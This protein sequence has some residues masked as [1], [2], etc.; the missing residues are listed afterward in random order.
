[1]INGI[2]RA[3]ISST[4]N[5]EGLFPLARF[6]PKELLPLG[7][8]TVIQKVVDEVIDCGVKD[9]IFISSNQ[10]KEVVNHFT[11]FSDVP[12]EQEK[13]KEKYS[14][15]DFCGVLQKKCSDAY[16]VYRAKEKIEEDAFIVIIPD[17]VFYGKK[18]SVEQI[19]SVYRTTQKPVVALKEALNYEE[20]LCTVEVEKI[21]NRF[22]K[23]KSINENPGKDDFPKLALAGRYIFTQSIFDY[24]GSNVSIAE[25]LNKMITAGKT[26]YGNHCEGDWFS[27][28]DKKSYDSAQKFFL[29]NNL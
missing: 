16:A 22:Y 15:V 21:A 28:R 18:S 13:F 11:V 17:S 5:G 8:S 7:S 6:T 19:F 14:D 24:V 10:K 23:I 3:I 27:L 1:M 4:K 9:L 26:I 12:E 2:K 25:S 20:G 29:E